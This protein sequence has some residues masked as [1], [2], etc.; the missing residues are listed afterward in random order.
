MEKHHQRKILGGVRVFS[1][2]NAE[3]RLLSFIKIPGCLWRA[4]PPDG[5][6]LGR[7]P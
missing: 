7:T 3:A 4:F 1:A 5:S 6:G 2:K